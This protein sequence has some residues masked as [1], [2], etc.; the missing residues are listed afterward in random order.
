M[1]S[2]NLGSK[3]IYAA[4]VAIVL[5]FV[6]SVSQ[7]ATLT[8]DKITNNNDVDLTGQLSLDVNSVSTST[9]D[10]IEFTFYNNVG[11]DSSLTDVY[12][13]YGT[14]STLF[15]SLTI[16]NDSDTL[17]VTDDVYFSEGAKTA[18]LPGANGNPL[19]FTS[20]YD[21]GAKDVKKGLD[22]GGEWVT[23]LAIIGDGS[24][25][26]D[27]LAGLLDGTYSIGVKLQSIAD[28]CITGD[29]DNDSSTY[30]VSI[31]PVP[32]AGILFAS[33]LFGMGVFG[34]RKKKSSTTVM[35]GAFARAS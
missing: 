9:G 4:S 34:R 30:M 8:F 16:S 23:F 15:S 28:A 21:A 18:V 13:D 35:V 1:K 17:A 26:T 12:F 31:V 14:D 6:M 29:C 5:M 3:A 10:G 22:Q 20:D 11:L 27:F 24:S 19:N 32:A 2:Y 7:A 25:Y 33:A